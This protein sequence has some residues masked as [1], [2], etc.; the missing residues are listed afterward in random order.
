MADDAALIQRFVDSF[1]RLDDF[2]YT[3]DEPPPAAL[4]L[5][6]DPD[7]WNAIRW[8]PAAITTTPESLGDLPN[9]ES[10][11]TLYRQLALFFRWLS[12]DLEIVRLL[13][14]PPGDGLQPLADLMT[15]DPVLE[16]TLGPNGYVRFAMASDCYDPICFDVNRATND[17]CPIV[18]LNHESILMHDRIGDVSMAFNSFRDLVLAVL[19]REHPT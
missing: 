11:P 4:S 9:H 10:L 19:A 6:P 14:N 17:D 1:Q 3:A 8:A 5:G 13:G 12:V 2:T 16:N 7:D 18:R 15:S